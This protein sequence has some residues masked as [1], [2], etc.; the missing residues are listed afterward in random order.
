M[1]RLPSVFQRYICFG[2]SNYV[3]VWWGTVSVVI[4]EYLGT[5]NCNASK[6]RYGI[7]AF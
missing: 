7:S 1:H 6:L 5:G 2:N 3:N 4:A